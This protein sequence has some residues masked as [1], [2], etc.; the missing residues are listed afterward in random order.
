MSSHK[1]NPKDLLK[2][3]WYRSPWLLIIG[4]VL[5][6]LLVGLMVLLVQYQ[7]K[8][9]GTIN[10]IS[11]TY[12]KEITHREISHLENNIDLQFSSMTANA[13]TIRGEAYGEVQCLQG[14]LSEIQKDYQYDFVALIDSEGNY[15]SPTEYKPAVTKI[16]ALNT[17]IKDKEKIIAYNESIAGNDVV[18]FG[19]P[20]DAFK[21]ANHSFIALVVGV[22]TDALVNKLSLSDTESTSTTSIV[23]KDGSYMVDA[24][25]QELAR[26]GTNLFSVLGN[27]AEMATG[28]TLDQMKKDMAEGAEGII[29][30]RQ[31]GIE[32][33]LYYAQVP[34]TDWYLTARMPYESISATVRDFMH[35]TTIL[36]SWVV[37]TLVGFFGYFLF[38]N[39]LS[40][41]KRNEEMYQLELQSK[42]VASKNDFLAKMSHDIRTPLNGIIGMNYIASTQIHADNPEAQESLHKVDASANYLL[43]IIN[44]ILDMSKI[45]SGNMELSQKVFSLRELLETLHT[46][47]ADLAAEK[48]LVFIMP[49]LAEN[50]W[51][52][53]GDPLRINQILMNLLSNAF[54]FTNSGQVSLT[55]AITPL[56]DGR[57]TVAFTV[58][59]TGI[60]MSKAYMDKLFTPFV[61]E[62][63][64]TAA[65]YG[66][67]GLGLSIVKN[68]VELMDGTL[69][70]ESEKG[71]GT[72]F[73]VSIPL[74]RTQKIIK[75]II[76]AT[77]SPQSSLEGKRILV[78]E[79]HAINAQIITKLLTMEGLVVELAVNGKEALDCF[80]A[81]PPAY[82]AMVLMDIQMPV[83]NGLDSTRAMR[84]S[85]HADASTIPICAMSANAFDD[86]VQTSLAAGMNDH[87]K[88]PVELEKLKD[89][90][91]RYIQ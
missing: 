34:D 21:V 28:F 52:Y 78:A 47:V 55:T 50:P 37:V 87:L 77:P 17:L 31:R 27:E 67:S 45:E 80:E 46:M 41:K 44:D 16:N 88:K 66:G 22:K 58:K 86:D 70:V 35:T 56:E 13:S 76:Q 74:P 14:E 36:G 63:T 39:A 54:K 19:T 73:V 83:M 20:V 72:T 42:V 60:G 61:Q 79:D 81:S 10:A 29:L 68:L 38:L 64:Q 25:A 65:T 71:V 90:L 49:P 53:L 75:E 23:K 5:V 84:A 4:V 12:L 8:V 7:K 82:Y 18:L 30:F 3:A 1:K 26:A 69:A 48:S 11:N 33:Y 9:P 15:C 43:S 32:M 24:N 62:S 57:D 91:H 51:D 2:A 6:L 89:A 59:D 40:L 85:T